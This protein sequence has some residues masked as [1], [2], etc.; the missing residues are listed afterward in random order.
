MFH[1][2]CTWLYL[3]W[4]YKTTLKRQLNDEKRRKMRWKAKLLICFWLS[5]VVS[6]PVLGRMLAWQWR[7]IGVMSLI[8]YDVKFNGTEEWQRC[9]SVTWRSRHVE[10]NLYRLPDYCSVS[11]I[12]EHMLRY[13]ISRRTVWLEVKYRSVVTLKNHMRLFLESWACK[14]LFRLFIFIFSNEVNKQTHFQG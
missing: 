7:V 2:S 9:F 1:L 12:Y 14:F 5:C 13:C 11:K 8:L 4:S 10:T 6:C 3:L